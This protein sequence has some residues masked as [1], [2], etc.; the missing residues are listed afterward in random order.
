MNICSLEFQDIKE[1]NNI[2]G[3]DI[4]KFRVYFKAFILDD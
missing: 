3:V 1:G 4:T 2:K